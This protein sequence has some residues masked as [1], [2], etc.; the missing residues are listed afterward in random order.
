MTKDTKPGW[1]HRLAQNRVGLG[2]LSFGESTV[3]PIPLEAIAVPLMVGHPRR[4]LRI[5]LVIW[6]GCLAGASLFYFVGLW[7]ADPV[8]KPALEYLGLSDTYRTMTDRL[9]EDGLFWSVFLVSL[10]PAPMQ[11]ATLGAGALGGNF[12][13]FLAAI[14]L[15][16]GLRYFGMAILAQFVGERIAHLNI[17]KRYLVP[18][19]FAVLVLGWGL[20]KLWTGAP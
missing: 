5:A 12:L 17:P 6:L 7:L 3:V 18:G 9:S 14:V 20:S 1:T 8:V 10:L 2:L 15:S 16:R 4:A 13:T 19:L 11:L